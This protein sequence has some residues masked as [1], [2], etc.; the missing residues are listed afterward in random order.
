MWILNFLK[1]AT[2]LSIEK[3]VVLALSTVSIG[4]LVAQ[5]FDIGDLIGRSLHGLRTTT[6][7][8]LFA[9]QLSLIFGLGSWVILLWL[10]LRKLSPKLTFDSHTATYTDGQT[11]TKYCPTCYGKEDKRI[12]MGTEKAGWRC[13]ISTCNTYCSNPDYSPN[14]PRQRRTSHWLG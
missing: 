7:A 9:I 14:Q 12:P 1:R 2:S 5:L 6:L 13:S 10:K 11:D 8:L 4:P 3:R